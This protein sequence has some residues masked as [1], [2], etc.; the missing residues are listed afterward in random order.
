[1][2]SGNSVIVKSHT[3]DIDLVGSG[4]RGTQGVDLI[5]LRQFKLTAE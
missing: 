5:A 2:V 4:I 3:S 1:V